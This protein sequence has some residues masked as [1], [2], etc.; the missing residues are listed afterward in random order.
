MNDHIWFSEA[1]RLK[2][3]TLW[4]NT[5]ALV[6]ARSAMSQAVLLYCFKPGIMPSHK[7]ANAI[8]KW[9]AAFLRGDGS[10]TPL[11]SQRLNCT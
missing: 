1:P 11:S 7:E 2:I 5:V 10:P 3:A 4:L 9:C 6:D 8:S